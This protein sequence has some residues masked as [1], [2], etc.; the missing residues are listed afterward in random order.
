MSESSISLE[1]SDK[2]IILTL[3]SIFLI[4]FSNGL[5]YG[6]SFL[7]YIIVIIGVFVYMLCFWWLFKRR[8]NLEVKY[9]FWVT[10]LFFISAIGIYINTILYG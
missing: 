9:S 2:V 5:Y 8:K 3:I 10:L 1:N 6:M 7:S 4:I